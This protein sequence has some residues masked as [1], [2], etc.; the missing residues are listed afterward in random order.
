MNHDRIAQFAN[1]LIACHGMSAE[2]VARLRQK[3]CAR[4][5]EPE[6]AELWREVAERVAD[7]STLAEP[8][9][10]RDAPGR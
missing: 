4:R 2:N 6:W 3:R 5:G 9:N 10:Y 8:S 1:I 7:R